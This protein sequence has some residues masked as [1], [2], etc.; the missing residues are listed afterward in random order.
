VCGGLDAPDYAAIGVM[1]QVLGGNFLSRLNQNL[2][3]RHGYTYGVVDS[4]Q[5][6]GDVAMAAFASQNR[7]VGLAVDETMY[8]FSRLASD[9]IDGV[10]IEGARDRA[11]TDVIRRFETP[12]STAKS[13]AQ[14]VGMNLSSD[15]FQQV[16]A[17]AGRRPPACSNPVTGPPLAV[18]LPNSIDS[19]ASKGL[20][21]CN[22]RA[23][24][25]PISSPVASMYRRPRCELQHR[26]IAQLL[27]FW[28][29]VLLSAP[30]D[31]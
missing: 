20:R 19:H 13:F 6:G 22:K 28:R 21:R 29:A 12:Y 25:H 30:R 17:Q 31:P 8:E 2:R 9:A 14:L 10:E 1:R 27:H 26:N 24:T 7:T 11:R 3:E 18:P 16:L 4:S 23:R 15:S 5:L